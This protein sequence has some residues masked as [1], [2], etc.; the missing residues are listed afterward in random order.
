MTN[1]EALKELTKNRLLMPNSTEEYL[2]IIIKCVEKS[3]PLK[4]IRIKSMQNYR[5]PVCKCEVET[6]VSYMGYC[7]YCGQAIDWKEEK[8]ELREIT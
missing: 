2:D 1:E 3:I 4:P 6:D 7:D 5:C 8:N